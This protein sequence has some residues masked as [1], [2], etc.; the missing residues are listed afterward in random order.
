M[1]GRQVAVIRRLGALES[2]QLRWGLV[3]QVLAAFTCCLAVL[4]LMLLAERRRISSLA[5]QQ[6]LHVIPAEECYIVLEDFC[7]GVGPAC[8]RANDESWRYVRGLH[9]YGNANEAGKELLTFL[10]INGGYSLQVM[11]RE[12]SHIQADLAVS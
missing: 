7:A 3:I 10:S 9:G 12:K 11:V 6:A 4:Q 1:C 2:S 8:K 5:L